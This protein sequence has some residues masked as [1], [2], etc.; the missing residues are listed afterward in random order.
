MEGDSER[1]MT[2][3]SFIRNL[4]RKN[5]QVSYAEA[6]A[7]WSRLGNKSILKAGTFY[8][9]RAVCKENDPTSEVAASV[10]SVDG[11]VTDQQAELM[12]DQLVR[13]YRQKDTRT[14]DALLTARRLVSRRLLRGAPSTGV[15]LTTR[16]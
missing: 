4:Y 10:P 12:L 5:P 7:K 2:Y 13:T 6:A 16:K 8:V 1:P 9:L 11:D 14:V 15:E 3:T